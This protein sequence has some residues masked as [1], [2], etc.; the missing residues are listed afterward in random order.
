ML[1]GVNKDREVLGASTNGLDNVKIN[2]LGDTPV[3]VSWFPLVDP[4][5]KLIVDGLSPVAVI[6][7][8][9]IEEPVKLKLPEKPT[10]IVRVLGLPVLGAV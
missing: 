9:L 4:A 1:P 3:K 6:A 10:V 5:V 7:T 2:W 8:L